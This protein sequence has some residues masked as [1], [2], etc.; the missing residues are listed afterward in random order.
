MLAGAWRHV[1]TGKGEIAYR[2]VAAVGDACSYSPRLPNWI[3]GGGGAGK[4]L[5][6]VATAKGC[7]DKSG[8]IWRWTPHSYFP[9]PNGSTSATSTSP[10]DITRAD[11]GLISGRGLISGHSTL[12][13]SHT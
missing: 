5:Q 7:D 11:F 3:G 4:S 13:E 2:Y 6:V 12:S 8:R 1:E 10:S 9:Q